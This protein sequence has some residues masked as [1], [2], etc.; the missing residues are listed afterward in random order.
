MLLF[1]KS[2]STLSS[3]TLS[4][5]PFL[6]VS[7]FKRP[8]TCCRWCHQW[9]ISVNLGGSEPLLSYSVGWMIEDAWLY[10]VLHCF[11]LSL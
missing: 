8:T 2:F 6:F 10:L 3:T 1:I 4:F 9:L 5:Q 11:S 7:R